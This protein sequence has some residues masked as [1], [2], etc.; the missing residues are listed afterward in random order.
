MTA[1]TEYGLAS[2]LAGQTP[3]TTF[4]GNRIWNDKLPLNATYPA[5]TFDTVTNLRP[6]SHGGV[7]GL[8]QLH[9]QINCWAASKLQAKRLAQAVRQALHGISGTWVSDGEYITVSGA[10]VMNERDIPEPDIN[11]AHVALDVEVR[12]RGEQ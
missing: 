3:V 9:A 6:L 4:V 7:T 12:V 2:Y 5:I 11:I 1:I 10:D 8:S